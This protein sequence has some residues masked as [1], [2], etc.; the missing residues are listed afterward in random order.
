MPQ[1]CLC[2][3]GVISLLDFAP[4]KA[5]H[6]LTYRLHEGM[7]LDLGGRTKQLELL[8]ELLLCISS[9]DTPAV[10]RQMFLEIFNINIWES[11]TD[12]YLFLKLQGKTVWTINKST[13]I[14]I[15][16]HLIPITFKTWDR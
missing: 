16:R 3:A 2:L 5:F 14:S 4:G 8:D 1:A 9:S 13:C 10:C 15:I 6:I 12:T 7:G 11:L